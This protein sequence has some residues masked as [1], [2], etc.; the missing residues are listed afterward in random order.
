LA[1]QAGLIGD[2]ATADLNA[3]LDP[4]LKQKIRAGRISELTLMRGQINSYMNRAEGMEIEAG[5]T[6]LTGTETRRAEDLNAVL[7]KIQ[8]VVNAIIGLDLTPRAS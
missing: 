8:E 2:L 4:K 5:R 1:A 7:N 3:T 6:D